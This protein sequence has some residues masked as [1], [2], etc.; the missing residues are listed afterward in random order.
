MNI[1]AIPSHHK[2]FLWSKAS[3]HFNCKIVQQWKFYS[4]EFLSKSDWCEEWV[5]TQP[6]SR[7]APKLCIYL[8]ILYYS[9]FFLW[10]HCVKS[11]LLA[12]YWVNTHLLFQ[13]YF[14]IFFV[15]EPDSLLFTK[16]TYLLHFCWYASCAYCYW[17]L[18]QTYS[19]IIVNLSECTKF[20]VQGYWH[21]LLI[22]RVCFLL[23]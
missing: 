5:F 17:L 1:S 3:W 9:R 6:V 16:I 21:S 12:D 11:I 10:L 18:W 7:R 15:I 19:Y 23:I 22:E 14:D 4:Y 13:D 8:A 2:C 20:T